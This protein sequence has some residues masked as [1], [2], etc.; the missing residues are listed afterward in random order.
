M[1]QIYH[2]LNL[3]SLVLNIDPIRINISN[4]DLNTNKFRK[5]IKTRF[6]RMEPEPNTRIDYDPP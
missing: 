1:V 3:I 6:D 2:V 5:K 4:I